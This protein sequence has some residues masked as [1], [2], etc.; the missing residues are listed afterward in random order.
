MNLDNFL[1]R[2][3]RRIVERFAKAEACLALS[4]EASSG[5]AHEVAGLPTELDP[6][7][8]E[9]KRFD[10]LMLSLQLAQLRHEPGFGRLRD[11]V[12]VIAGLLEEKSAIPSIRDQ[13]ALVQSPSRSCAQTGR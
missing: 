13:M 12:K 3:H 7:G 4:L 6:E 9:A 11:R 1:V 10:L 8:E 2:P 5:L